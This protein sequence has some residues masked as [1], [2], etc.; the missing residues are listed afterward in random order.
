MNNKLSTAYLILIIAA[1]FFG[2]G[3]PVTAENKSNAPAG[4][5]S[6]AQSYVIDMVELSNS[7]KTFV[8]NTALQS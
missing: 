2:C 8:R 3:G 6:P 4:S 1:L 5:A 7:L